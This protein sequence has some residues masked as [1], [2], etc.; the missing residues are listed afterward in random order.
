MTKPYLGSTGAIRAD[1]IL[2]T[3]GGSYRY[4]I[5]DN[6][7]CIYKSINDRYEI[8]IKGIRSRSYTMEMTVI[9]WELYNHKPVKVVTIISSIT[10]IVDLKNKLNQLEKHATEGDSKPISD[11]FTGD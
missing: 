1:K 2:R 3:L 11:V 8:L 4:Q 9:L 10:T 7:T 6:E 5:L